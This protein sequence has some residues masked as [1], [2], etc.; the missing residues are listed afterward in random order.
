M[1]LKH[2]NKMVNLDNVLQVI[3]YD[4]LYIYFFDGHAH[5]NHDEDEPL[6][7]TGFR[8]DSEAEKDA[9]WD[10]HIIPLLNK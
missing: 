1:W 3:K 6:S 9:Y 5:F 4:K 8:F 10:E 2:K 7:V